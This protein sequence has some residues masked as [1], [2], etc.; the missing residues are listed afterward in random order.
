[1]LALAVQAVLVEL[2][3]QTARAVVITL[4]TR[5]VMGAVSLFAQIPVV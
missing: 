4:V 1:M 2:V 3:E 5:P